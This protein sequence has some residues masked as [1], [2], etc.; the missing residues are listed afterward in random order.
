MIFTETKLK[1]AFIL[2]IERHK[3]SSDFF[4]RAFCQKEFRHRGLK[5][6]ST[7]VRDV[8]DVPGS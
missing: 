6:T 1:G 5:P 3:D 2:T 4:G 8:I 7:L